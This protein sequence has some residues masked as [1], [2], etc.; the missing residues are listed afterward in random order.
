MFTA[1]AAEAEGNSRNS[2]TQGDIGIGT[3]GDTR[4]RQALLLPD[5]RNPLDEGIL[6]DLTARPLAN[7]F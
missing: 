5:G 4:C 6:V 7:A 2:L 1:A 3:S